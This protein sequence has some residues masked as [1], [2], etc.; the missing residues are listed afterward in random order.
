MS[1]LFP[2]LTIP[3]DGC[4]APSKERRKQ[5]RTYRDLEALLRVCRRTS[6]RLKKSP[7]PDNHRCAICLDTEQDIYIR[8]P[9]CHQRIGLICLDKWLTKNYN[10]PYCRHELIRRPNSI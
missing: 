2:N 3:I 9:C 10:C 8:L 5:K 1:F 7:K 6:K 4:A